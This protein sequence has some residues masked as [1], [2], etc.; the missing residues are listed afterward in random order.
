VLRSIQQLQEPREVGGDHL[1]VVGAGSVAGIG[2]HHERRVVEV[3][4][5]GVPAIGGV[6][7]VHGDG[8]AGHQVVRVVA[9]PALLDDGAAHLGARVV[10]V[11]QQDLVGGRGLGDAPRLLRI[12]DTCGN[13]SSESQPRPG[14]EIDRKIRDEIEHHQLVNLPEVKQRSTSPMETSSS[15]AGD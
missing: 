9:R 8:G 1:L 5:P 14:S 7:E 12:R 6:V 13:H 2:P 3:A 11:Q 15:D 10:E 4:V